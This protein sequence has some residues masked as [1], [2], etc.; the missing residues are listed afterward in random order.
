MMPGM[1]TPAGSARPAASG[2]AVLVR[3]GIVLAVGATVEDAY[4]ISIHS[5]HVLACSA[6]ALAGLV[7][8]VAAHLGRPA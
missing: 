3:M 5:E 7:Q 8:A 1:S 4:L 2:Y 6:V